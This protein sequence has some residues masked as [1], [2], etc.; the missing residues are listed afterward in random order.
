M[1]VLYDYL[2][3]SFIIIIVIFRFSDPMFS[4]KKKRTLYCYALILK[5]IFGA[6]N[7]LT[8]HLK[9][10]SFVLEDAVR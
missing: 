3:L 8:L 5:I 1:N 4:Y 10:G 6:R 2:I 7:I 9:Y